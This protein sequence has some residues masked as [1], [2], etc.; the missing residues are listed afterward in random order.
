[1]INK[2]KIERDKELI[3]NKR[4]TSFIE[5][6][7]NHNGIDIEHITYKD[8]VY[9][10]IYPKT[11]RHEFIKNLYDTY[12]YLLL[13]RQNL[14]SPKTLKRFYYIL[15]ENTLDD[16]IIDLLINKYYKPHT[17]DFL[18]HIIEM[19]F[20]IEEVFKCNPL[21]EYI[22]YLYLN[23]MLVSNNTLPI[24]FIYKQ[25]VDFEKAKSEYLKGNKVYIY[26]TILKFIINEKKQPKSHYESLKAL[27]FKDIINGI[28]E[29]KEILNKV[30]EV[31]GISL[32][33]S[34]LHDKERLDSDIDL[35]VEFNDDISYTTKVRKKEEL[36]DYLYHKFDRF[37]DILELKNN[38]SD[39]LIEII[40]NGKVII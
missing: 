40:K 1:M 32:Y 30:Y 21:K 17:M 8:L 25:F 38:I 24:R 39:R 35:L 26:E 20:Y 37:I 31:K 11:K 9:G 10:N 5:K 16:R 29:E 36:E 14:F 4:S 19:Y 15:T 28:K 23:S 33:G 6:L 7:L 18:E 3:V 2:A 22:S 12:K 34:F 13:N 27:T